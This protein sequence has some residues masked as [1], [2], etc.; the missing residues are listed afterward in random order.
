MK[1]R[2]GQEAASCLPTREQLDLRPIEGREAD[3][4]LAAFARAP[5][6]PARVRISRTPARRNNCNY[7]DILDERD[8]ARPAVPQRLEVL[9]KVWLIRGQVD[10]LGSATAWNPGNC[11]GPKAWPG[12]RARLASGQSS[13]IA[14]MRSFPLQVAPAAGASPSALETKA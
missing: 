12:L 8:L 14:D 4:E 13:S 6:H 3:E 11:G 10:G 2:S 5:G 9:E 1:A 7:R